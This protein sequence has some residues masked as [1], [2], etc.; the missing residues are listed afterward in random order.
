[1]QYYDV[2]PWKKLLREFLGSIWF[3]KQILTFHIARTIIG[4][5]GLGLVINTV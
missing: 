4:W 3:I 5:D 1:M 2:R